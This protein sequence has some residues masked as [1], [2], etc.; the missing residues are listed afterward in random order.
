MRA[1]VKRFYVNTRFRVNVQHCLVGYRSEVH[2][3]GCTCFYSTIPNSK[4]YAGKFT[5]LGALIYG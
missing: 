3:V 5:R 2:P 4:S 1:V